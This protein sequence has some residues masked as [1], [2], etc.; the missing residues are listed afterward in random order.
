MKR[1]PHGW[2]QLKRRNG[3]FAV[4]FTDETGKVRWVSVSKARGVRPDEVTEGMAYDLLDELIAAK[5][6]GRALL[7]STSTATVAW[8]LEQYL[9]EMKT[10][11]SYRSLKSEADAVIRWIGPERLTGLSR[12]RLRVFVTE[13]EK[14][15]DETGA[16]RFEQTTIK[17]RLG[18]FHAAW[19][20]AWG[21]KDLN[22]PEPPKFPKIEGQ[23]IRRVKIEEDEYVAVHRALRAFDPADDVAEFLWWAAFRPSEALKLEWDRVDMK[24][25]RIRLDEVDTKTDQARYREIE[26][27]ELRALLERRYAQ[28]WPGC[29]FV[30]HRRGRP[31]TYSWMNK[32][33]R[34]ACAQAGIVDRNLH[35]FRRGMYSRLLNAE[36]DTFTAM[37][38][39]GHKSLSSARRYT[40]SEP[41]R[42]KAG[43]QKVIAHGKSSKLRAAGSSHEGERQP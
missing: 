16:K 30:F 22:V 26:E 33:W 35:D 9:D 38:I 41:G 42:Q 11:R 43:L 27:P 7:P 12:R 3:H 40:L 18:V 23:R 28:R 10:A 17:N 34:R 24:T 20:W 4:V 32:R 15:K 5:K 1:R 25:W 8:V 2:G 36:V 6:L 14:L 37:E 13:Y 39:V 21:E 29:P 19:A 31:V